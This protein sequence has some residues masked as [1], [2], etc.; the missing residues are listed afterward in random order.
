MSTHHCM[1]FFFI[2]CCPATRHTGTKGER[3]YSSYLFLTSGLDGGEWS[4][5]CPSCTLPVVPLDG[6]LGRPQSWSGHRLQEK[7]FASAGYRTLVVQSVVKTLLHWLSYSNSHFNNFS[8][9]TL[10]Q[11]QSNINHHHHEHNQGL[12]LKTCSFRAQGN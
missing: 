4:V 8:Y 7:S 9:V 3:K 10:L 1:L 6:M 2:K 5:S 11:N 12:G